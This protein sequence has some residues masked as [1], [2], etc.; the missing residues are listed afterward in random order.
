MFKRYFREFSV[1]PVWSMICSLYF[2]K[3]C[4]LV[5]VKDFYTGHVANL[6][7]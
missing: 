6:Y 3:L 7:L 1:M 2:F 5:L 4:D